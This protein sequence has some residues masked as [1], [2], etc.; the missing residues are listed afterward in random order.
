MKVIKKAIKIFVVI[1]FLVQIV[2]CKEKPINNLSKQ[3]EIKKEFSF[4]FSKEAILGKLNKN[5]CGNNDSV[6]SEGVLNRIKSFL[7]KIDLE[8]NKLISKVIFVY[9]ENQG[10]VVIQFFSLAIEVPNNSGLIY[11]LRGKSDKEF[12]I[13]M[14][15]INF[16]DYELKISKEFRNIDN[17]KPP[18]KEIL[19]IE[20]NSKKEI[21][22]YRTV[23]Q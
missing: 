3:S 21:S 23:G 20:M 13:D 19:M 11:K 12:V 4:E 2:S 16:H 1:L 8:E 6:L 22:C 15:K 14:E 10:E 17:T 5:V 7:N 9:K 18:N